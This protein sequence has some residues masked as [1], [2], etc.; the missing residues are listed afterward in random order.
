MRAIADG[1]FTASLSDV[2]QVAVLC[3]VLLFS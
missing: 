1:L 2:L 3:R